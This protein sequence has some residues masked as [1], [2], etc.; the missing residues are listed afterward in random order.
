MKKMKKIMQRMMMI[1][2]TDVLVIIPSVAA[3][4]PQVIQ[5]RTNLQKKMTTTT[6]TTMAG[7][8]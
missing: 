8:K 2:G 6:T 5:M 1:L 7:L 4:L 3:Q